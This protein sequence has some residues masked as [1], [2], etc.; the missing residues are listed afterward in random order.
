M[1]AAQVILEAGAVVNPATDDSDIEL[2]L[3]DIVL[4]LFA[5]SSPLV[6]SCGSGAE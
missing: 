2:R 5:G 4:L 1:L 6:R 3:V